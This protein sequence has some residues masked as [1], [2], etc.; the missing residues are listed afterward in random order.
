MI[1]SRDYNG[2]PLL[3]PFL[4]T[5]LRY[6]NISITPHCHQGSCQTR[7][8]K[9]KPLNLP[10]GWTFNSYQS[11]SMTSMKISTH[12]SNP[13]ILAS[14]SAVDLAGNQLH[15]HDPVPHKYTTQWVGLSTNSKYNYLHCFKK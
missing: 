8:F 15:M 5:F 13:A 1:Q 14:A 2:F 7:S 10:A 9:S 12:C 6:E 3:P 4:T 11:K